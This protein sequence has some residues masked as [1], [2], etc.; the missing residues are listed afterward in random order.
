MDFVDVVNKQPDSTKKLSNLS[1]IRAAD[2][3]GISRSILRWIS[4]QW[5]QSLALSLPYF[6][7]GI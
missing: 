5:K 6:E 1:A 7:W 2:L 4:E 3:H